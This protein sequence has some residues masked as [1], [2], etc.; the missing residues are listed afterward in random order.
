MSEDKAEEQVGWSHGV[1]LDDMFK[2]HD[3]SLESRIALH[4]SILKM[5]V[6]NFHELHQSYVM[7][8]QTLAGFA[9]TVGN[10][11]S[12]V[13]RAYMDFTDTNRKL[14]NY[15][16]AIES[17]TDSGA[18]IVRADDKVKISWSNANSNS[19]K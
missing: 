13:E 1:N 7:L 5:H 18:Y 3:G 10:R 2:G 4:E 17:S 14:E 11:L 9:E 19:N 16:H 15:L 8:S 6:K 12:V